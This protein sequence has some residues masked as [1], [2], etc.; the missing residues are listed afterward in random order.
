[1]SLT[2]PDVGLKEME[3]SRASRAMRIISP[4]FWS[5]SLSVGRM[6]VVY[7]VLWLPTSAHATSS[8]GITPDGT[9]IFVVNP[10][11]GSV[12]AIDTASETKLDELVVGRDPR[13]LTIGPDGQRLYVTSQASAT[14]TILDTQPFSIRTKLRVGPEPYG[15][16]A[17]PDGHLVYVAASGAARIDVVDTELA[18]VVDTIATQARP[19]GLALSNDGTRLYVTHFLSGTVSVIDLTSRTVLAVIT[20]GPESNIAQR[21]VLHPTQNRAYLPHIRSNVSNPHPLFDTTLFPVVS[22]IDVATDQHLLHE[23]LELSVVD[24]PVNLPFDLA[25]S[26][27]GQRAHI[28]YLGSGDLSVIDLTSR[29]VLAHLEVGDGPRG[30]VL[31]PDD[32]TAYVVNSLSDDVSVVDLSTFEEITRIPVTTSPLSPQ[33]KR[34]KLLFTSSR[35]TRLSRDRWMSCESC[36][37][38]GEQDGRT[39]QFP[40]GPRNTTNLRGVAHT[41]PLHWSADRDEAQDFEFTIR[42]LQAGTGLIE[43]GEPHPELGQPN[44]GL[45]ADLDALAAFVESLQPKPSPFRLADGTLSPRALRG[46]VVFHRAD[47]GCAA[48]H[49]PP[50]FIDLLGHD[51]GTGNGPGEL[52]GPA[53]DTPSL[54]GVWHTAPYLHDGRAPTLRDVLVTYNPTN[55]HGQTAHLSEAEVQDL[56]AFLR[57]L[58]GAK[59]RVQD[60][61]RV[62]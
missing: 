2:P 27:D 37:A 32:R 43:E 62:E 11:S 57:S 14:L 13:I 45:S 49:V 44:A 30:I 22:V 58:E 25:L 20:T 1:M 26:S 61:E 10:D 4:L 19:K 28:V 34:G 56:V 17:D 15:V 52:L 40:D 35:S 6:L 12:S 8:I 39:W 23:R 16:V 41:H 7:G 18:Q 31:T 38:D 29:Q 9:T 3:A 50:L 47:V 46:Q 59:S 33:M 51:I 54:R 55:Q 53:F 36:H 48:C 42:E 21:I 5:L 60:L 24:R